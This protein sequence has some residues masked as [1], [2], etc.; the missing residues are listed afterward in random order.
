VARDGLAGIER[1]GRSL[2]YLDG[3]RLQL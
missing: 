1:V 2:S 3:V